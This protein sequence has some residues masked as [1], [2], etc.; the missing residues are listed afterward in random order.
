MRAKVVLNGVVGECF[1]E[2][3][4]LVSD[5]LFKFLSLSNAVYDSLYQNRNF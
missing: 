4:F 2:L 3:T 1:Y 5:V